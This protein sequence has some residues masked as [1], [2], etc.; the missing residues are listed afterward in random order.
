MSDYTR[1]RPA[2]SEERCSPAR[3]AMAVRITRRWGQIASCG[4]SDVGWRKP[5]SFCGEAVGHFEERYWR[6]TVLPDALDPG[7]LRLDPEPGPE[8]A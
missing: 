3:Q 2:E 8:A 1:E 7:S 5:C 4:R 6:Y